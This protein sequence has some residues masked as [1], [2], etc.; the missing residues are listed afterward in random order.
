MKKFNWKRYIK[1]RP[2]LKKN[3]NSPIRARFHFYTFR[4][5]DDYKRKF[6]NLKIRNPFI[7]KPESIYFYTFH[8]CASSFF[9]KYVFDNLI[10]LKKIDYVGK[11]YN[12]EGR[13][14]FV[15]RPKGKI[16]GPLRLTITGRNSLLPDTKTNI[17]F[18]NP[19]FIKDK[20]AIF[21][22]RDPRDVLVSMYYSFGFSHPIFSEPKLE[23]V[24]IKRRRKIQN[25]TIDEF[26]LDNVKIL[27]NAY[28][29]LDK[30]KQSCKGC[31]VLK[32][33]DMILN[34]DIFKKG[35]LKYL[36]IKDQVLEEIYSRTRPRKNE[37]INLHKRS[38]A[39]NQYKNKLKKQTIKKLNIIFKDILETYGYQ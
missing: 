26:A 11:L 17:S 8:K 20:L 22:I 25:Q 36:S 34:W 16:Y 39:V 7:K 21:M 35:L 30:L 33:E 28:E 24:Q 9:D 15:L 32:Y 6:K 12:L 5:S 27:L 38:G 37:D 4:K 14:K 18:N 2:D 1:S 23:A 29:T 19:E 31:V 3:W 13:R 10:G